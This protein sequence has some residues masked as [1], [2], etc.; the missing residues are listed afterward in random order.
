MKS[1]FGVF[2]HPST[3]PG[4]PPQPPKNANFGIFC[5]IL[6][7]F[8]IKVNF[9]EIW[10][11]MKWNPDLVCFITPLPPP[12]YHPNHP[13]KLTLVFFVQFWWNL[14]YKSILGRFEEKWSEILIWGVLSPLYHPS[15]TPGLPPQ[16][17]QNTNFG[18]F[19]PILMKFGMEVN[20]WQI[21]RKMKRNPDLECFITPLP[22]PLSDL[23]YM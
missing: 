12:A 5:P 14:V 2:Y 9:G 11:K 8:G 13:K 3:T 6:M 17:P 21:W 7:K 22:T 1:W 10:R 19:C 4:L 23:F 15:T 18:I 16:P 20:L